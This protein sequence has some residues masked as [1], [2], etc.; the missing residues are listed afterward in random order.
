MLTFLNWFL[1]ISAWVAQVAW[2]NLYYLLGLAGFVRIAWMAFNEGRRY[3]MR[4]IRELLARVRE[5]RSEK[6]MV[7]PNSRSQS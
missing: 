2:I 3:Q 6:E 7:I 1:H 5:N 4:R